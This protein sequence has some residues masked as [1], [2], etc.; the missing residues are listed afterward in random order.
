MTGLETTEFLNENGNRVTVVEMAD[1][2]APGA[3][4]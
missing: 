4:F 3:W 2:I 1:D